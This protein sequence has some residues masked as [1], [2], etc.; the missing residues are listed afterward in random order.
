MFTKTPEKN[1]PL[2]NIPSKIMYSLVNNPTI[3]CPKANPINVIA[4]TLL[5][6]SISPMAPQMVENNINPS[7]PLAK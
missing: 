4:R 7:P 2:T 1:S 3:V 6:S 5:R